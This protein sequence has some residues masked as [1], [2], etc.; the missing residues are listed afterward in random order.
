MA[1]VSK[2]IIDGTEITVI[3]TDARTK[4]D[5]ALTKATKNESDINALKALSR[6]TISYAENTSTINVTTGTHAK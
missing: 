1:N 3:D 6:V 5:S 4:S 2:F